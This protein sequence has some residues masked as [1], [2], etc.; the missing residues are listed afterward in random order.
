MHQ[1]FGGQVFQQPP[2]ANNPA[3]ISVVLLT[4]LS[5]GSRSTPL[6]INTS[7]TATPP[8]CTPLPKPVSYSL[9][10]CWDTLNDMMVSVLQ[11][12]GGTVIKNCHAG[13][14]SQDLKSL[15]RTLVESFK[16]IRCLQF[17]PYTSFTDPYFINQIQI[18]IVDILQTPVVCLTNYDLD[19]S[20]RNWMSLNPEAKNLTKQQVREIALEHMVQLMEAVENMFMKCARTPHVT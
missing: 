4:I 17:F 11:S 7:V 12:S 13:L 6:N 9:K 8:Y 5:C 18:H 2:S 15:G 14:L 19:L 16:P 1:W 3:W 10:Q 20:C